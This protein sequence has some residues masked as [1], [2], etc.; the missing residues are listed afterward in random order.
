MQR[1]GGSRGIG[2]SANAPSYELGL[3]NGK[4]QYTWKIMKKREVEGD[5]IVYVGE[6]NIF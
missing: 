6:P 3:P 2:N 4:S 5:E 1:Y